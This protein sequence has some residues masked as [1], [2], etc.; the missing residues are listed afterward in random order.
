MW[1]VWCGNNAEGIIGIFNHE[2]DARVAIETSVKDERLKDSSDSRDFQTG[3]YWKTWRGIEI[4]LEKHQVN[5]SS[6]IKVLF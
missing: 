4:H 2:Y 1:I 5:Y 3:S 6:P